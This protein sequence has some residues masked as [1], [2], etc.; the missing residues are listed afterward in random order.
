M[1]AEI[2]VLERYAE[3]IAENIPSDS[4]VVEL[5]SGFVTKTWVLWSRN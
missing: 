2:D 3:S 1:N 5:G 4:I